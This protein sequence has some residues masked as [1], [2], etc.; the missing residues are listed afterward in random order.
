MAL[1]IR[2]YYKTF[3][4]TMIMTICMVV[5]MYCRQPLDAAYAQYKSF[6]GKIKMTD[7]IL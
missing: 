7:K 6:H 4:N 1:K 3:K 2:A 5:D